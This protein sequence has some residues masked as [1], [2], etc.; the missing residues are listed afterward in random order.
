MVV[1]GDSGPLHIATAAEVPV[2]AL[3][4]STDPAETG[5]WHSDGTASRGAVLYDAL[6]CAPCRKAPTCGGRFNCLR[7][8]SPERVFDAVTPLLGVSARQTLPMASPGE[9]AR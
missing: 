7:V 8:L 3:F 5:P 2:V 4:G 9:V 6:P 1:S